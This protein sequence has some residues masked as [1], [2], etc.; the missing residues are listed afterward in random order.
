M[1]R[2]EGPLAASH[3]GG[4][5]ELLP[6]SRCGSCGSVS[7]FD[8]LMVHV[9]PTGNI[10]ILLLE[11]MFLVTPY[12]F[13]PG[14]P[15]IVSALALQAEF[16]SPTAVY[17]KAQCGKVTST[18]EIRS[19]PRPVLVRVAFDVHFG[20]HT[21]YSDTGDAC[22]SSAFSS[23]DCSAAKGVA[24]DTP[25]MVCLSS[26]DAATCC[27]A[28]GNSD[29]SGF[30][31]GI[32]DSLHR[33]PFLRAWLARLGRGHGLPAATN[34]PPLMSSPLPRFFLRWTPREYVV[35]IGSRTVTR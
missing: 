6:A 9:D 29:P 12:L 10:T 15:I 8:E 7:V 33:C 20:Y 3:V 1:L 22:R 17:S 21:H 19:R 4:A 27:A 31:R 13:F 5:D 24:V 28:I 34:V 18:A 14:K 26:E 32:T 35:G 11:S 2:R 30:H 23:P 25:E 16:K